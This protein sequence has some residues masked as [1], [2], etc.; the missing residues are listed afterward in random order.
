[1]KRSKISADFSQY[2]AAFWGILQNS[3]IYDSSCSPEARVIL[4]AKDEGYFL[5][6]AAAGSLA[7]EAAMTRYFHKKG[8]GAA[9][10][11]YLTENGRDWLLT[12]RV[13]GEDCTD[14]VYL[15]DPSRLCD[16]LATR[17]RML[18]EL[19]ATD[20][21]VQ[22]RTQFYLK[23]VDEGYRAGRRDFSYLLADQKFENATAAWQYVREN[24]G[25]LRE[26]TL[27]HGD[28]CLPNIVLDNWR[29]SG[30][31]DVGNGGVGDR[32]IDLFWGAWTLCFNLK[33]DA[34]RARFFDAYG[35]DKI[36]PHL[37]RVIAAA[38]VFG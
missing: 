37:L 13:Q 31:I 11:S 4:I 15:A 8:L 22:N 25:L 19:D 36:E 7:N 17:L 9:V 23:T 30:F 16:L 10:L 2:P 29:F 21:P 24:C 35:R 32:H 34:Y 12:T 6:S 33:T 26:D 18:H 20:C 27:L 38:E 28:Y 3:T 5:K 14:A 1:M